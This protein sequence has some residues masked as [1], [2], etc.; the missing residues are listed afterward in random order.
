MSETLKKIKRKIR[1]K[2]E[3]EIL[4]GDVDD[5][6]FTGE[7]KNIELTLRYQHQPIQPI[8]CPSCGAKHDSKWI[9]KK[10]DTIGLSRSVALVDRKGQQ[11]QSLIEFYAKAKR[12]KMNPREF[13][14]GES[15][16]KKMYANIPNDERPR[17]STNQHIAIT[18]RS[19]DYKLGN[20]EV[21]AEAKPQKP[22]PP[23]VHTIIHLPKTPLEA[24]WMRERF[25]I[26]EA[27]LEEWLGGKDEQTIQKIEDLVEFQKKL[28]DFRIIRETARETHNLRSAVDLAIEK[29]RKEIRTRGTRLYNLFAAPPDIINAQIERIQK[30][31]LTDKEKE[32]EFAKTPGLTHVSSEIVQ[33]LMKRG[34]L[35]PG[36]GV[37]PK[38][39]TAREK[40][41]EK[42]GGKPIRR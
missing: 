2:P 1:K 12:G 31:T 35:F 26:N 6:S 15:R 20:I 28:R 5:E 8:I 9:R 3:P 27:D 19:C 10:V 16:I 38:E 21:T 33:D 17:T 11:N 13:F 32:A 18:C 22:A 4:I 34:K 29:T 7:L 30:T 36:H 24:R 40:E 39:K 42:L 25:H 23:D 37:K 14:E 41:M